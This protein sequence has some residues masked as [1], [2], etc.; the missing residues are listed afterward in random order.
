MK[1]HTKDFDL[2]SLLSQLQVTQWS[3]T[4]AHYIGWDLLQKTFCHI[5]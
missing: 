2:L 1:L 3:I 5:F 4:N